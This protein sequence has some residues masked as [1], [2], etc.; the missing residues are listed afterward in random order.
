MTSARGEVKQGS[1]DLG[2]WQKQLLQVPRAV[3]EGSTPPRGCWHRGEPQQ[4]LDRTAEQEAVA[5]S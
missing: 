1:Q 4:P 3:G 5:L 2:E